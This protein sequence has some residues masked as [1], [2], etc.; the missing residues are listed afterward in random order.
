MSAKARE[1]TPDQLLLAQAEAN[2]YQRAA[3]IGADEF[4][5]EIS[6]SRRRRIRCLPPALCLI[7]DPGVALITA[8][9]SLAANKWSRKSARQLTMVEI[10]DAIKTR[11]RSRTNEL[12]TVAKVVDGFSRWLRTTCLLSILGRLRLSPTCALAEYGNGTAS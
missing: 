12:D 4:V 10:K 6:M 5:A 8:W 9:T 7:A 11:R 3:H 2:G 1:L